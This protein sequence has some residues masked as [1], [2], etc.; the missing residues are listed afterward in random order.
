MSHQRPAR[1]APF[2]R[3]PAAAALLLLVC[4]LLG[5][6]RPR[7]IRAL[8]RSAPAVQRWVFEELCLDPHPYFVTTRFNDPDAVAAPS[9]IAF[10]FTPSGGRRH[11]LAFESETGAV[12]GLAVDDERNH[13]YIG[14]YLKRGTAFGPGG[15]GAI[16]R[17]DLVDGGIRLWNTVP[18][19]GADPHDRPDPWPDRGAGDAVGLR[20]LG[21]L[22]ISL[23]DRSLF[24]VNLA[25]RRIYRYAL[26]SGR[27]ETDF[28][29]G[30]ADEPW[31][32][33]A[34]PFG[35]KAR[36]GRLYHGLVDATGASDPSG[37]PVAYVYRSR[38]SGE[39]MTRVLRL[40][41]DDPR[42]AARE[43]VP[44][45]W[46]VW[47]AGQG[48]QDPAGVDA[49]W[50]QP[51]L[52]DIE[53]DDEGALV[54]GLRD[55]YGDMTL[56]A[57]A[58]PPPTEERPGL[59]AGDLHRGLPDG[60]GWSVTPVPEHYRGDVGP[61][62][63]GG[64]T[65]HREVLYGG[66]ARPIVRDWTVSSGMLPLVAASA[67]ALWFDNPSGQGLARMQLYG[68][69]AIATFSE[70]NGLGD[71]ERLCGRRPVTP[72]APPTW[73]PAPSRTPTGTAT[74]TTTQTSTRTPSATASAI[75]SPTPSPSATA[76]A[77]PTRTPTRRPSPTPTPSPR[78]TRSATAPPSPTSTRT[79]RPT[80]SPTPS[81]YRTY[82]PLA[83][84]AAFCP[85]RTRHADVVLVLDRSTSM[86][87]TAGGGKSKDDAAIDAALDF[88]SRLD[89]AGPGARDGDRLALVGF[90]DR[91][92]VA[93]PMSGDRSAAVR[94]LAAWRGQLAEGT[95]LD[96]AL[97]RGRQALEAA[98]RPDR[99]PVLV[100]LTDGLPNRVPTPEGG[101]RQEDTV[102]ARA[103]ELRAA[104]VLVFAV[105]LGPREDL[106]PWLLERIA[107]TADRSHL[108]PST[109]D[110]SRIYAEIARRITGCG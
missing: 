66:L 18:R 72:T 27:L 19:A 67:G 47:R 74:P 100:L 15:P 73:T 14:A 13:V 37:R 95:R 7:E 90:H 102:L 109:A 38:L 4:A 11:N 69:G 96:L 108:A 64:S 3:L 104:G 61:G 43:P 57:P 8:P 98:A 65:P 35:L 21:D 31:A 53:F 93:L 9:L 26:D 55:R 63:T 6:A 50:P 91:A 54:L 81:V 71:V 2:R 12:Y 49:I 32:A 36:G 88:V 33:Q 92:W 105:G 24:V 89:L 41:L 56:H 48:T 83:L 101:G 59:P 106:S 76:S 17:L 42:D 80:A 1:L 10:R 16:Y 40:S 68:G 20:S 60:Q 82:L 94:A 58:Q 103:A 110:L 87:R 85:R 29:H 107:G 75:P 51:M 78:P 84:E 25:D 28:R 30:A 22:D 5:P 79:P 46:H 44:A 99:E 39:D 70:N 45:D 23:P 62:P 86:R 97:H 77:T 52:A 34:R